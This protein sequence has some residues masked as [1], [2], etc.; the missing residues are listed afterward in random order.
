MRSLSG[1]TVDLLVIGGGII[2]AGIARDAALRGLSVALVEQ[3][4]F[5][6]G[7]TSRPTRLIHGGLRYLELFD[8]ALVRSDMREREILLR[9]A[10]HLVFPLP[11]LLPLYR[12]SLWYQFK[13]RI[14]M[15]LYDALSLDK[16]LPKRKWLDRDETLAAE[17]ALDPDGLQGAW[18]FYDAQVPLV[19]RLVIENVVD[20]SEHGA[21]VLNH[22]KALGYLR[23]GARVTGAVVRD[24]IA[25][26]DLEVRARFTVNATGPW[27]DRTIASVRPQSK[28]LLRLTK[29]IHLVTPPATEK[30]HVLF[31]KSDGRLFFVLPWLDGTLVGTTDTDY[32]GDPADAAATEEDVRYLQKEAC[33]AF[34]KAPFDTIH[35]TYAGVRA[36]VREEGVSEG[37][38]SRKHA[39]FDHDRRDGVAGLLSVVGGKITAYRDIA[40]EATDAVARKLGVK[41]GGTTAD[42]P[43]PGA[44]SNTGPAAPRVDIDDETVRHLE[45]LYG[46]RSG[47]LLDLAATHPELRGPLCSHHRGIAAE[48]VYAVLR[49]WANTLGDV[50]LRRTALGLMA[51][52]GLDCI[53]AVADH[54]GTVLG[55]DHARRTSEIAA[56]RAEIAPMRR[57][58]VA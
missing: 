40:E 20:A 21:L 52:Q 48:V 36:L 57:F 2:G 13:L 41:A 26:T 39:L 19:E 49:E 45:H 47:E 55:W 11:F 1:R 42:A 7:T 3:D 27:L 9:I 34:P 43:L 16:S 31:A 5:A 4:D 51:C 44:R 46:T 6:S 37:Q 50:L 10:P 17:P 12:P 23:D 30:A 24:K 56:Y 54:V 35:Y 32:A 15:Q 53:E 28:P 58:S 8:F 22:A 33:R 29:G 18:R 14:G 25:A 38:V